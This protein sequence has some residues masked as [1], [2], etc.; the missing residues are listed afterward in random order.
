MRLH[1]MQVPVV[2][3]VGDGV[4]KLFQLALFTGHKNIDVF[5]IDVFGHDLAIVQLTQCITQVVRQALLVLLVGVAF[6]RSTRFDFVGQ[7][8]VNTGQH[9][10][11]QQV[12]VGIGTGNP[13]FDTHGI[14]R[15]G[16][17]ADRDRTVVQAPARRVRHVELCAET[18]VGVDV[19]AKERH[20]RR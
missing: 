8:V 7:T 14:G 10:R 4:F 19:R 3:E 12:R 11:H 15:T 5:W 18:T 16:R 13:V 20:L 2:F 17:Y 9:R 1:G 6:Y